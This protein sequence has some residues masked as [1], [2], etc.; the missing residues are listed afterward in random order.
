MS[1]NRNGQNQST[2]GYVYNLKKTEIIQEL[3]KRGVNADENLTKDAL[4]GQL[5][6]IARE[7]R[8][9]GTSKRTV[10]RV[11]KK[12]WK[13]LATLQIQVI[14]IKAAKTVTLFS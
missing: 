8:A 2:V 10:K 9:R 5:A 11:W 12:Q 6:D 7:E 1:G 3:L 14:T 4:R 13:K